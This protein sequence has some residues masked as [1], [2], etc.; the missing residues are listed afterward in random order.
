[1]NEEDRK[2]RAEEAKH[3][4]DNRLFKEAFSAVE[5]YIESQAQGCDPDNKDR[6]QRII[7][8]KQIMAALRREITRIVEDGL[9]AEMQ[10]QEIEQRKR[11]SVFRR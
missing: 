10:I 9:V 4:L 7:I 11:F 3:L 5:G 2:I 1:M 6:A 8:S